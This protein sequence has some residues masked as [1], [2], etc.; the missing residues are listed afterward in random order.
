MADTTSSGSTEI[1]LSLT[2]PRSLVEINVFQTSSLYYLPCEFIVIRSEIGIE[3]S[4]HVLD[5]A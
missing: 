1:F 3:A 2:T 5:C 4:F